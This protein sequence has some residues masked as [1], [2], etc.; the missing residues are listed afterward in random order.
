MMEVDL[1]LSGLSEEELLHIKEVLSRDRLLQENK[2]F[3]HPTINNNV[4]QDTIKESSVNQVVMDEID[5][6][7]RLSPYCR[8]DNGS[9][10]PV[11]QSKSD[12]ESSADETFFSSF[13]D[14]IS[15]GMGKMD[16]SGNDSKKHNTSL[17]ALAEAVFKINTPKPA[18]TYSPRESVK[19]KPTLL[20]LAATKRASNPASVELNIIP[21]NETYQRRPRGNAM[22]QSLPASIVKTLPRNYKTNDMPTRSRSLGV[23][24]PSPKHKRKF[25]GDKSP[26]RT[27]TNNRRV[28][29]LERRKV[30][31][32]VLENKTQSSPQKE[33][34]KTGTPTPRPDLLPA[35]SHIHQVI[36][37]PASPM[38]D[39]R[40]PETIL[41]REESIA[42]RRS[43]DSGI[44]SKPEYFMRKD[45]N[46]SPLEDE[47]D[48]GGTLTYDYEPDTES[49]YDLD[50]RKFNANDFE[51][52][53]SLYSFS[54]P[55]AVHSP[56]RHGGTGYIQDSWDDSDASSGVYV[57]H[58]LGI[59]NSGNKN[60]HLT[61]HST[62]NA[63][64]QHWTKSR[65]N[66]HS[67][68]RRT[69]SDA[70]SLTRSPGNSPSMSHRSYSNSGAS[71]PQ[72]EHFDTIGN[73]EISLIYYS[74]DS[75]ARKKGG[76]SKIPVQGTKSPNEKNC[77]V[78]SR[79]EY[80]EVTDAKLELSNETKSG[81]PPEKDGELHLVV[82]GAKFQDDKG[83]IRTPNTYVKC[84]LLPDKFHNS[85]M[86]SGIIKKSK[87]PIW[88]HKFI[89]A[90]FTQSEL[91][92]RSLEIIV[93]SWH[94]K[95]QEV[96]GGAIL[97]VGQGGPNQPW[98]N[99]SKTESY[100]WTTALQISGNKVKSLLPLRANMKPT[101][102]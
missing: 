75:L 55:S 98:I 93:G 85:K 72:I 76:K 8:S 45:D 49:V 82:K 56:V 4:R 83:K 27:P 52:V 43:Q 71:S 5:R 87:Q 26:A 18:F 30:A 96:L 58:K 102:L 60:N 22:F 6:V 20:E 7:N 2:Q 59:R 34:Q 3:I 53:G 37:S 50:S 17:S 14:I 39:T 42:N 47:T 41:E 73:L 66:K 51:D 31:T 63:E 1:N 79:R 77:H 54:S 74:A 40:I 67:K 11:S 100:V 92:T 78:L 68:D 25:S 35:L 88:D 94:F 57:S 90:G 81:A 70:N 16:I 19:K 69:L 29:T 48:I 13:A 36:V 23:A 33:V 46:D 24:M 86:K 95:K 97:S 44:Y 10:T 28:A 84:Y 38:E 32:N 101:Y 62:T 65:G 64:K 12:V 9:I 80:V 61:E 99:S 89:L 15:R 91:R 21:E